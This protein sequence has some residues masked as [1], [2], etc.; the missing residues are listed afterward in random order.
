MSLGIVSEKLDDLEE[1]QVKHFGLNKNFPQKW[2]LSLLY[3]YCS[4]TSSKKIE[5]SNEIGSLIFTCENGITE[6]WMERELNLQDSH[7][8][9]QLSIKVQF[10]SFSVI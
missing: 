3:V 4:L 7:R 10:N 2:V 1:T 8:A 6:S 9:G 5:K